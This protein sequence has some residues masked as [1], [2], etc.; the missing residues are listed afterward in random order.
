VNTFQATMIIKSNPNNPET[1]MWRGFKAEMVLWELQGP[2][3]LI[4][5]SCNF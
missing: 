3:I 5:E 1:L 4:R 2:G